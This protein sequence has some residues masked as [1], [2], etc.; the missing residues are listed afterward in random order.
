MAR[1]GKGEG[2]IRR[3][4]DGRWEARVTVPGLSGA[5]SKERVSVYGATRAEV[6][7]R[8][9]AL[10]RDARGGVQIG[11]S[12]QLY[13]DYLAHWL[14]VKR[15][16]LSEGSFVGYEAAIRLHIAPVIGAVRMADLAPAHIEL[17]YARMRSTRLRGLTFVRAVLTGSLRVAERY[18]V[19]T[20]NVA[21]LVDAPRRPRRAYAVYS[22]EE[23]QAYIEAAYTLAAIGKGGE[24]GKGGSSFAHAYTLPLVVMLATGLRCGELR[25]LRWPD[26]DLHGQPANGVPPSLYVRSS[27]YWRH[28][29]PVFSSPKTETSNRRVYLTPQ[30]VE[31]LTLWRAVQREQRLLAGPSWR[32]VHVGVSPLHA[33]ERISIA[34]LVCTDAIG[35]PWNNRTAE[36]IHRRIARLAGVPIIR[37]H[38]LRHTCATLL[39]AT[40]A[41]S[42]VVSEMLGHTTVD[43]TLNVYSH[44]QPAMAIE[45]VNALGRLLTPTPPAAQSGTQ[46]D[47]KP[48]EPK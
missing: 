12:R 19:V 2:T 6:A 8:S 37:V 9:A 34:G 32:T 3:R 31:A 1:R 14:E 45:A 30:A 27:V 46:G 20:R 36:R 15:P 22:A 28:R 24:G 35:Q 26:V 25:A 48:K 29:D 7:E 44:V 16:Q 5:S 18:G 41:K 23:A 38:D 10:L 13:R 40:D 39:M 33:G 11:E 47:Q 4:K 17:V 21:A 42:K 43:M